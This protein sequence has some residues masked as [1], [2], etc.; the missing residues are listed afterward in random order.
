M[1]RTCKYC[2]KDLSKDIEALMSWVKSGIP[3]RFFCCTSRKCR[4]AAN[5]DIQRELKARSE[6]RA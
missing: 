4:R 3:A 6:E 1:D 5:K 2:R